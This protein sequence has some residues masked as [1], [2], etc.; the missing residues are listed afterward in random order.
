[1]MVL[2]I[3]RLTFDVLSFDVAEFS[4]FSFSRLHNIMFRSYC[5]LSIVISSERSI[6]KRFSQSRIIGKKEL[7]LCLALYRKKNWRALRSKRH[8]NEIT[9]GNNFHSNFS[10]N[11]HHQSKHVI[12]VS[13]LH[14]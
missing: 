12:V 8:G 6:P 2:I 11:H 9:A 3:L 10:I 7:D 14:Q 1:M 13:H 4:S 5:H